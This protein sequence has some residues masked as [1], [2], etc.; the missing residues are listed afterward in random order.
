MGVSYYGNMFFLRKRQNIISIHYD[1]I[2]L[3]LLKRHTVLKMQH[4]IQ[5]CNMAN[6]GCL[7][8]VE[9]KYREEGQRTCLGIGS[10]SQLNQPQRRT[11][12]S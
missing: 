8:E 2:F 1:V 9:G 10:K 7:K 12:T 6:L 11:C 4:N 5:F 3:I